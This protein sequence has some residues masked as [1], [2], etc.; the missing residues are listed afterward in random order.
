MAAVE[1]IPRALTDAMRSCRHAV[2]LTGSGVSAESGVPTFRDAQQG[3]WQ[4][5]EPVDLATPE[6]FQ[7]D[8]ELVWRWYRWRRQL[9][10]GAQP[11]G[12][13]RALVELAER[14]PRLTLVTQNVD[15][16]HQ[17]AG[18]RGVI[19]FHGNLFVDACSGGCADAA[20]GDPQATVPACG[21]CGAPMRPGVVWFGERIP[22]EA[23]E[24]A[25]RAASDCDLFFSIGT[26]SVV[27]PAA[28]LADSAASSGARVVEIN[29]E[30]TPL[31]DNADFRLEG[32]SGR[33]LPRLAES[34]LH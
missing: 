2:V 1:D 22:V 17:Q 11:N 5:Y 14:L 27:W 29:P 7:R 4:E 21:R 26:S 32:E 25:A 23:I 9:V 3:L 8:P 12:G 16:L 18:S 30:A 20:A 13:H 6:A 15:G 10:S 24:S 19:E 28:G 33:L 34:L 31:S